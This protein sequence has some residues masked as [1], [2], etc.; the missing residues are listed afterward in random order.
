MGKLMAVGA[1]CIF[2][3][4]T[5][6]QRNGINEVV[7][8][9]VVCTSSFSKE[10]VIN[11]ELSSLLTTTLHLRIGSRAFVTSRNDTATLLTQL[12]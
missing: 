4:L 7:R 5:A 6:P 9:D 11:F 10:E 12:F 8:R 1:P 3:H 2:E